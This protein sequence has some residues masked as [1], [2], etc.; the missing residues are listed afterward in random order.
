VGL[1][2]INTRGMGGSDH[3]SFEQAGV[4]GFAFQQDPAEY[5]LT[6]HSQSDTLDKARE[7]ELVQGA[8]VMA[9]IGLR[10]ANLPK[11]LPRDKPAQTR[12]DRG[13]G[14][15]DGRPAVPPVEKPAEK[16]PAGKPPAGKAGAQAK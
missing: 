1:A 3:M 8:E 7:D 16:A 12:P 10:V 11:M 9:V 13:D 15:R 14:R 5:R 2:D 4:P 6:H